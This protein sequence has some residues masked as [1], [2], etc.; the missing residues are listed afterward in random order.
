MRLRRILGT[1][2]EVLGTFFIG[3]TITLFLVFPRVVNQLASVLGNMGDTPGGPPFEWGQAALH[4]AI[5]VVIDALLLYFFIVRPT[6]RLRDSLEAPGLEVRKGAGRA[7]IDTESVRQRVIA[8]IAQVADIQHTDVIVQ[9]EAGRAVI[10]LNIVTD[11]LLNGPKK[12][13]EI[14]REVRKIVEDQLGVDVKGK[15]TI[16]FTLS[17]EADSV[18]LIGAG[19]SATEA[20]AMMRNMPPAPTPEPEMPPIPQKPSGIELAKS[21]PMKS[22]GSRTPAPMP[23]ASED[24]DLK[25]PEPV[26][27]ENMT[28]PAPTDT[29]DDADDEENDVTSLGA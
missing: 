4:V 6:R 3:L 22:P 27:V 23:I 20:P 1:G 7:Y 19:S 29:F 25:P 16:I 9:N 15:P 18:P 11:V 24:N 8:A 5:A 2:L 13:N 12:K 21:D 26:S 10:R 17:T 14:N 28:A